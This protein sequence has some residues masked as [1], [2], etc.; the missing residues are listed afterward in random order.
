MGQ[1]LPGVQITRA[2]YTALILPTDFFPCCLSEMPVTA[3]IRKR[4]WCRGQTDTFT[5]LSTLAAQQDDGAIFDLTTDGAFTILYSF[6]NGLDGRYP[7]SGLTVGTDG[8]L[9]GTSSTGGANNSGV[10]FKLTPLGAFTVLHAFKGYGTNS[11]AE[12]SRPEESLTM[13]TNGNFFG[14]TYQGGNSHAG[15][16]E[17]TPGTVFEISSNGTA[18]GL[19]YIYE[20][21]GWRISKSRCDYRQ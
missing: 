21:F 8:N 7:A 1:R 18:T 3:V 19:L 10:A 9:Y 14:T 13:G 11:A 5:E 16:Y 2:R 4:R 17:P 20:W 15:F 12:G 6:T